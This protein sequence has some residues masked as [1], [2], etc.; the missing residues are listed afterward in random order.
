MALNTLKKFIFVLLLLK[1][2]W[3]KEKLANSVASIDK[4]LEDLKAFCTNK[5]SGINF[6]SPDHMGIAVAF[7]KKQRDI[8]RKKI[9]ANERNERKS[10]RMRQKTR[11][12]HEKMIWAL[13]EHF[14]DRHF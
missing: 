3:T 12:N 7:L 5:N 4:S 8:I 9:E 10:Q 6:C 14:L 13:R 2:A 11:I 1:L